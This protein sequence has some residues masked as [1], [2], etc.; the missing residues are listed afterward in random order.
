MTKMT[1]KT[2]DDYLDALDRALIPPERETACPECGGVLH[3]RVQE[4]G[5][6]LSVWAKCDQCMKISHGDRGP[7]FP[8]WDLLV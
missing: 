8:G 6:Y 1:I 4:T 3:V 5:D 7:K 2:I